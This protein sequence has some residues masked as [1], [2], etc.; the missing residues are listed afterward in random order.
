[1]NSTLEDQSFIGVNKAI[2]NNSS[3]FGKQNIH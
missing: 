1:M 3:K 2:V